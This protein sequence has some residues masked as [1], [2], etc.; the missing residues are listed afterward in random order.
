MLELFRNSISDG[1]MVQIYRVLYEKAANGD[2]SAAKLIVAYKIGK[3]LPAADPD[4]IDRDE[5]E[6]YQ[7]DAV[8]PE[9]MKSVLG[10]LPARVGNDIA[11][12][13][14][15]F[16]THSRVQQLAAGLTD[17]LQGSPADVDGQESTRNEEGPTV[18]NGNSDRSRSHT[19]D[20]T[21]AKRIIKDQVV[22]RAS[23]KEKPAKCGGES[24]RQSSSRSKHQSPHTK[25]HSPISIGKTKAA[26][27][28]KPAR[29]K[30]RPA[31][32]KPLAKQLSGRK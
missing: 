25:H 11:R 30:T 18:S 9:A 32:L 21:S 13:A 23:V 6:H 29:K 17:G 15:P 24:V 27:K 19:S 8:E 28:S 2:T 22:D 4:S 31:W 7:K 16:M 3:P 26:S 5:W 1:E 12:T 10:S 14:L 20:P